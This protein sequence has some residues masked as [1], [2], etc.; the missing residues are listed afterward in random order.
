MWLFLHLWNFL[1][2]VVT[3]FV[4]RYLFS[5]GLCAFYLLFKSVWCVTVMPFLYFK[6]IQK[7]VWALGNVAVE[8]CHL[9]VV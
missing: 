6:T 3:M 1:R 4:S 2:L 5:I 9:D 8:E 7:A